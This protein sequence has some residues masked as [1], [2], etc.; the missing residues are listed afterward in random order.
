MLSPRTWNVVHRVYDGVNAAL[1]G[2]LCA[3]V[4]YFAVVVLPQFPTL[5]ARAEAQALLDLAAENRFYC[6]KWGMAP[7][8]ESYERCAIDLQDIRAKAEQRVAEAV[9]FP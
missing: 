3:G 1:W 9:D 2:L 8:S 7:G 6:E 5:Q 4:V